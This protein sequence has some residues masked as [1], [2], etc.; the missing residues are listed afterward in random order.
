MLILI[1]DPEKSLTHRG[2]RRV[3]H[4]GEAVATLLSEV[5]QLWSTT[6]CSKQIN[7]GQDTSGLSWGRT[8]EWS[9]KTCRVQTPVNSPY[10]KCWNYGEFEKDGF[11]SH[12][13]QKRQ[14]L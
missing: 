1:T 13:R 5:W 2:R 10:F 7:T 4:P 6:L 8:E 11:H 14:D 12:S 3:D 9:E